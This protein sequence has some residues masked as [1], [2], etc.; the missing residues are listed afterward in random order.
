MDRSVA[1]D[2]HRLRS[3]AAHPCLSARA[4]KSCSSQA[5]FFRSEPTS[6]SAGGETRVCDPSCSPGWDSLVDGGFAD[7]DIHSLR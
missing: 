1:T 7:D 3:M 4:Q 6:P 2:A 5:V